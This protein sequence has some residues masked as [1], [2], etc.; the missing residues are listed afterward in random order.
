MSLG[1]ITIQSKWT[2][3]HHFL[4]QL[5][6]PVS[7]YTILDNLSLGQTQIY[8]PLTSN[9]QSRFIN[10]FHLFPP[11]HF[12]SKY[13]KTGITQFLCP[14]PIF[15][16]DLRNRT[17]PSTALCRIHCFS[18]PVTHSSEPGLGCLHTYSKNEKRLT[19]Y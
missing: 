3:K 2:S 10:S 6:S 13:L 9:F 18:F 17:P 7:R 11:L 8:C 1:L 14:P 15:L 5:I 19:Q 4:K 16:E 12:P